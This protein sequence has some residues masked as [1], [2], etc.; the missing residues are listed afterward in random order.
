MR[1][2]S[3]DTRQSE[4]KQPHDELGPAVETVVA[5]ASGLT[6]LH[7]LSGHT[8]PRSVRLIRGQNVP[9]RIRRCTARALPSTSTRRSRSLSSFPTKAGTVPCRRRQSTD[10]SEE[11]CL[12]T[13][14]RLRTA[15]T[16][17]A[18]LRLRTAP[19]DGTDSSDETRTGNEYDEVALTL[20]AFVRVA[21]AL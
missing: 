21:S 14:Y 20:S 5:S 12:S 1:N 4:Y 6:A 7:T 11:T 18:L 3:P 17:A 10:R 13:V 8:S 9:Y 16:R 19:T 2:G 15:T